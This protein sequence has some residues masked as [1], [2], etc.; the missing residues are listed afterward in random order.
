MNASTCLHFLTTSFVQGEYMHT[1]SLFWYYTLHIWIH[2]T[3]HDVWTLHDSHLYQH[4]QSKFATHDSYCVFTN[5]ASTKGAET[6]RGRK[7]NARLSR[8]ILMVGIRR[9]ASI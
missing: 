4:S 5:G 1:H 9:G 8:E 6:G 2:L 3:A 7:W